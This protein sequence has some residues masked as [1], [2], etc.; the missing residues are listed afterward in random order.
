MK[1]NLFQILKFWS[2]HIIQTLKGGSQKQ[3]QWCTFTCHCILLSL[4]H[5]GSRKCAAE[6]CSTEWNSWRKDYFSKRLHHAQVSSRHLHPVDCTPK[7]IKDHWNET[8]KWKHNHRSLFNE[9]HF[10]VSEHFQVGKMLTKKCLTCHVNMN[11]HN[12]TANILCM[13]HVS[14]GLHFSWMFSLFSI[15]CAYMKY[16]IHAMILLQGALD[17]SVSGN[18]QEFS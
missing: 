14:L 15:R 1:F 9:K 16:C 8:M 12:H 18:F 5:K 4:F 10:L 17:V 13:L 3:G 2:W 11:N 6:I 7:K